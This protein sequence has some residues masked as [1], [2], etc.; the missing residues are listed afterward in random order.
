M[1]GV[2]IPRFKNWVKPVSV[3]EALERSLDHARIEAKWSDGSWFVTDIAVDTDWDNNLT[4]DSHAEV[5][6]QIE[7]MVC[8]DVQACSAGIVA[9]ETLDG[10]ALYNF[11]AHSEELDQDILKADPICW[12]ALEVL[13]EAFGEEFKEEE[14]EA[15]KYAH[16]SPIKSR[17]P[18]GRIIYHNDRSA[19]Q[20]H[21]GRIVRGFERAVELA[22]AKEQTT[23]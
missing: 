20:E 3:L 22:K 15:D 19:Q 18:V 17:D 6:K 16:G 2:T 11:L 21:H 9:I 8:T 14:L 23:T 12:G 1:N 7:G 4:A 13:A 10:V 5:T